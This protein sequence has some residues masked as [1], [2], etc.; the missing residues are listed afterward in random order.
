MKIGKGARLI[1]LVAA[2][3]LAPGVNAQ[4]TVAGCT[5]STS[6]YAS[7]DIVAQLTDFRPSV[8]GNWHI[9]SVAIRFTN[10]A[11]HP[12]VLGYVSGSAIAVDDQGNRFTV[13][14]SSVRGIGIINGNRVDTKFSLQPGE[15]AD[16]RMDLAWPVTRNKIFGTSWVLDLTVREINQVGA[17]QYSLGNEVALHFPNLRNGATTNAAAS[18]SSTATVVTGASTV[19]AAASAA[20]G[21]TAATPVVQAVAANLCAGKTQCYDAGRFSATVTSLTE[22]KPGENDIVTLTIR[23]T[24]ATTQPLILAYKY[25]SSSMIDN[26]GNRY[27]WGRAGSGD[28]SVQGIGVINGSKVDPS[29][30]LQP[31]ESRDARFTVVRYGVGKN[32]AI[33]TSFTYD[34]ALEQLELLSTQQIRKTREYAVHIENLTS[35][36]SVDPANLKDAV[37]KLKSL[38]G[39][40]K[41]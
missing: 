27:Y 5:A 25:K 34:V 6:C 21:A 12:I 14:N 38:F 35:H 41:P 26:L 33:G 39:H 18:T 3:F 11:S 16:A 23:F 31:G 4:T 28:R 10:R 32:A 24:N 19:S 30:A 37:N 29:F 13:N 22:S 36:A 2:L 20:P 9:E 15:S 17:T 40:K 1:P 8:S 7:R